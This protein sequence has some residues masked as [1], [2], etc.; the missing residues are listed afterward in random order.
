MAE[1]N[2]PVDIANRA[3][4]HCGAARISSL[5]EDSKNAS[6]V[7]FCYDK[8][9]TAELRRNVWRFAIRRAALRT[10]T[11]TTKRLAPVAWSN[12]T[13][14]SAGAIVAHAGES[15]EATATTLAGQEPGADSAPW[16]RYAG[17][18]SVEEHD[19]TTTYFSGELVYVGATVYRSLVS[20]NSDTPPT[21]NW[22]SIGAATRDLDILYPI[23]AGPV[24][25]T[26][27]RNVYLMPAGFLR[28]A[29]ADPKAGGVSYL[30]APGQLV[31][32]D[33]NLEG[34]YIVSSEVDPIILRFVANVYNVALMD[35]MFCEGLA[36]RIGL[37][38][39]ETLTQ[40][41]TKLQTIGQA[42]NRF[43]FEARA[44]NGIETG[45]TEPPLDDY[46]ACR[47]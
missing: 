32:G 24:T 13:V 12:V 7:A 15:W 33:W 16:D 17:P 14:Y 6:E 46:I 42:Y 47:V 18:R 19:A 22:L 45:S 8:L 38:V 9:R 26:E 40:S 43:M 2:N 36:C 11:D 31:Y 39:C 34:E 30:G 20:S 10:I 37:E 29:P 4:Q 28:E 41:T 25:N 44:V 23:G 3:L 5:T 1:F 27:T 21:A 35:P